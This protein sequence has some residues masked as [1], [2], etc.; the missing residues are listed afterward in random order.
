MNDDERREYQRLHLTKPVNGWFGDYSVQI[1]EVSAQGASFLHDEELPA[2]ARALL[3]F[4]WRGEELELTADL[5]NS[6]GSRSG[7]RFVDDTSR[8]RT[9]IRSSAEEVIR[10][11]EANASGDRER[12]VVG[13]QTLTAASAGVRGDRGY[14]T[15]RYVDD[16]WLCESTKDLKQPKDG[17]TVA[18]DEPQSEIELLQKTFMS[19][20]EEERRMTRMIAQLSVSR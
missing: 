8:L 10:A 15:F 9:L 17:F 4:V 2:G 12:N 19:G 20:G 18:A 1:L 3:R 16:A 13:D 6:M 7:V 11:Q 14:L 5:S